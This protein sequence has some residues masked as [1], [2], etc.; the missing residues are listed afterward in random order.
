MRTSA[1]PTPV[2]A[3][4]QADE[5]ESRPSS[6]Q[7]VLLLGLLLPAAAAMCY[8]FRHRIYTAAAAWPPPPPPRP[9]LKPRS[10]HDSPTD[11]YS[12]RS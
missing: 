9:T 4:E 10:P 11:P 6:L 1:A 3:R 2:R 5:L 12:T 8:P 7:P